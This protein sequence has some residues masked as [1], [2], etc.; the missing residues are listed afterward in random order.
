MILFHTPCKNPYIDVG[1]LVGQ[2]KGVKKPKMVSSELPINSV[3]AMRV[4]SLEPRDHGQNPIHW[5]CR[6]K[7]VLWVVR[8]ESLVA[9]LDVEECVSAAL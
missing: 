9:I 5:T 2:W 1:M 6:D 4:L 3:I 7:S 8:L